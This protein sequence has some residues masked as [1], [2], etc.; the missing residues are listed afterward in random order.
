MIKRVSA[1]MQENER[2]SK[3]TWALPSGGVSWSRPNKLQP[4]DPLFQLSVQLPKLCKRNWEVKRQEYTIQKSQR[5]VWWDAVYKEE[6]WSGVGWKN[7]CGPALAQ[8]SL[9]GWTQ[10]L[11]MLGLV[12]AEMRFPA[13]R[14][15]RFES[16]GEWEGNERRTKERMGVS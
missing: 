14:K 10:A 5:P 9:E 13:I 15:W 7:R 11:N 1:N 2:T 8:T 6:A 16:A 4:C 12:L 3:Q